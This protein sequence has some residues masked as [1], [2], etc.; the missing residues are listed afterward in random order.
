MT[1]SVGLTASV[2]F[3]S[4]TAF[5]AATEVSTGCPA[6]TGAGSTGASLATGVIT[7]GIASTVFAPS[8]AGRPE[9]SYSATGEVIKSVSEP[10]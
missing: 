9:L 7:G 8:T 2:G 4:S 6:D 1:A 5:G 3:A 10:L